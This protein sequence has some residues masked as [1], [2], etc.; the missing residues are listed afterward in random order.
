MLV[1]EASELTI[2]LAFFET[3]RVPPTV[4][5]VLLATVSDFPAGMVS[6][7]LCSTVIDG[8][9]VSTSLCVVMLPLTFMAPLTAR[10]PLTTRSQSAVRFVIPVRL[11]LEG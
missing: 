7:P 1:M 8:T 4:M 9:T 6:V 3:L 2:R 10:G 11:V 5:L